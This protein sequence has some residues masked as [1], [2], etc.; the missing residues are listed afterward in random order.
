[1]N[2]LDTGD[3]GL[4]ARG[5]LAVLRKTVMPAVL[6][7]VACMSY[8]DDLELLNTEAFRQKAA[9]SLAKSVIQILDLQ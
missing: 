1:V 5:D 6:A 9:E 2:G 4:K 8:P 3:I 7:E